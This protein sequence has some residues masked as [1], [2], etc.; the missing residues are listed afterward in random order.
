MITHNGLF[1]GLAGLSAGLLPAGLEE[2]QACNESQPEKHGHA[3]QHHSNESD[4]VCLSAG[5]SIRL[6]GNLQ[7]LSRSLTRYLVGLT[8]YLVGLY[9]LQA[10]P[11]V[12]HEK[13]YHRHESHGLLHDKTSICTQFAR[14]S[15]FV[16]SQY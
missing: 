5:N 7:G 14:N 2:E 11:N 8:R 4:V 1:W 12:T 15:L 13:T 6:S 10:G 9:A 3:R 16:V